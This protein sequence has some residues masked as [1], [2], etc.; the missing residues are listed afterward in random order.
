MPGQ[1]LGQNGRELVGLADKRNRYPA[2]LSGGQK[3]RVGIARALASNP[4]VLL[5]DEVL[6]D[7]QEK[8]RHL[9]DCLAYILLDRP[10]FMSQRIHGSLSTGRLAIERPQRG[11]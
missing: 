8:R 5:S 6:Y 11:E 2:E 7:A 10:R 9:V 4:A 3:Q 1:A